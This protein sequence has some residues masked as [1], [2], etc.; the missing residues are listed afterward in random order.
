VK[1]GEN[2]KKVHPKTGVLFTPF[3]IDPKVQDPS[4]LI[5]EF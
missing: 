2:W 5:S 3:L 1:D 4:P